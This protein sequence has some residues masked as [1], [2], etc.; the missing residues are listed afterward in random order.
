[1]NLYDQ[2]YYSLIGEL[3]DDAALGWVPNA[4]TLGSLCDEAYTRIL[5]ARSR[6]LAKL[7]TEEDPDLEQL[8]AEFSTIQRLLCRSALGLRKI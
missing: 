6:L 5:C 8:F 1:M 3:E 7:G 4:F 2:I